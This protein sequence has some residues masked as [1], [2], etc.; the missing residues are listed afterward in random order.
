MGARKINQDD[1]GQL[2]AGVPEGMRH[3]TA[4]RLAGRYYGKG[5]TVTEVRAIL[6]GWNQRNTPPMDNYE[7]ESILKSTEKW[8]HVQ[9]PLP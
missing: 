5:M 3:W 1:W 7:M 9:I 4:V 6:P 2:L 8:E